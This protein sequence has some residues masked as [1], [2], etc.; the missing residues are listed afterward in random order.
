MT[1]IHESYFEFFAANFILS[2]LKSSIN[3]PDSEDYFGY[4]SAILTDTKY[5]IIRLFINDGIKGSTC[6]DL[7][8]LSEYLI[9]SFHKNESLILNLVFK[10]RHLELRNF[11]WN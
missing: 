7:K 6:K 11:F 4:F 3:R 9:K 1:S 5:E 10:E 2:G 8:I